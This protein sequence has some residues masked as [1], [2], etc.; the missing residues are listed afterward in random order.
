MRT[1]PYRPRRVVSVC[2]VS[3][4]VVMT[5]ACSPRFPI[6]AEPPQQ[7]RL[8]SEELPWEEEYGRAMMKREPTVHVS[9]DPHAGESFNGNLQEPDER[10]PWGALVDVIAFPFR[11]LGW[12][13]QSVF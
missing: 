13:V 10:G 4:L 6:V 12:L 9:S 8:P 5:S 2:A 11:A 3:M 7:P 1:P